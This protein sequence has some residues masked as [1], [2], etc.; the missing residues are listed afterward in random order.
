MNRPELN[1]HHASWHKALTHSPSPIGRGEVIADLSIL[2]RFCG[3][4]YS[5]RHFLPFL[6]FAPAGVGEGAG[7]WGWV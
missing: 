4:K 5:N 3:A 1:I 6:R 2:H 7:G